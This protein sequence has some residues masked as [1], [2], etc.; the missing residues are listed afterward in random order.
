MLTLRKSNP[1]PYGIMD[2]GKLDSPSSDSAHVLVE[3]GVNT[4]SIAQ[5]SSE[6]IE[7]RQLQYPRTEMVFIKTNFQLKNDYT[8]HFKNIYMERMF[9]LSEYDSAPCKMESLSII[10]SKS[11]K[12]S[13]SQVIEFAY[14]LDQMNQRTATR[15]LMKEIES[16]FS[17][18]EITFVNEILLNAH[19]QFSVRTLVAIL[20]TT[21]RVK[22]RLPAWADLL[23][24]LDNRLVENGLDKKQWLIGLTK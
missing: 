5:N 10:E 22:S 14:V 4:N 9:L 8:K 24:R 21:L 16:S 11:L 17:K 19:K 23:R 7:N 20:R 13:V 3:Y 15:Y 18:N 2:I 6:K 1:H 12:E